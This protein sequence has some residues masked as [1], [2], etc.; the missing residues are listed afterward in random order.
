MG[1]MSWVIIIAI[2]LGTM[3]AVLFLFFA[4]IDRKET[5]PAGKEQRM[6]KRVPVTGNLDLYSG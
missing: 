3:D 4:L 6:E 2:F 1:R 5:G